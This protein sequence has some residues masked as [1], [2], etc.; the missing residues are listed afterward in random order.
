[1]GQKISDTKFLLAFAYL[2]LSPQ[3]AFCATQ[4]AAVPEMSCSIERTLY[5]CDKN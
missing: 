2:F 4:V 3:P 5:P 1:V